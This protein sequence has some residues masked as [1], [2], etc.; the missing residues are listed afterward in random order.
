M[1]RMRLPHGFS[2]IFSDMYLD[3]N[4]RWGGKG[5][6]VILTFV[7]SPRA[8]TVLGAT[9]DGRNSGKAVAHG[10]TPH[11]PSMTEGITAAINSCSKLPYGKFAGG[12]STMWDFDSSWANETLISQLLKVFLS[13]NC[14]IFQG[15]TTSVE[16]LLDAQNSPE[17]H[18]NLI[19]RVGGYSARFV[20][21]SAELQN[22]II[23]RIRHTG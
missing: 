16:E 15:N 6:P 22:D 2:P 9:A 19:V 11:S 12:A 18:K 8:A 17:E 20:N 3:Y 21:L 14:Q 4:T 10:V 5:K 23:S 13:K 7:Y 1:K